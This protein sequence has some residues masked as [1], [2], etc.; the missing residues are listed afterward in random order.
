M[1]GQEIQLA[2]CTRKQKDSHL[3]S[4][5]LIVTPVRTQ[6]QPSRP[7]YQTALENHRFRRHLVALCCAL[8]EDYPSDTPVSCAIQQVLN[9]G[10]KTWGLKAA[11]KRQ[12][13]ATFLQRNFFNAA[14]Q[15]FACCSV[16]FGKN[17]FRPA[18]KRMLQCNFCSAT[19]RKLQRNF[20]F[21]LWHIAGVGFRGVGFRTY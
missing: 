11:G 16:A 19:F 21:R 2:L 17:D 20:R 15:F 1:R 8:P 7:T 3:S 10:A 18:E 4:P 13:S 9:V 14:Q 6:G 5:A 12:E